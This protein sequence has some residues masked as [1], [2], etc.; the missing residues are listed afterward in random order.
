MRG[1]LLLGLT[2]LTA[3]LGI[4]YLG[5][6]NAQV[7]DP[8][9]LVA[10]VAAL[11][12]GYLFVRHAKQHVAPFIPARFLVGREF[13]LMNGI[14][15]LY[16]AAVLGFAALVPLYAEQRYGLHAL[17]AG[18]LLTARA[19]GMTVRGWVGRDDIYV[20]PAIGFPWLSGSQ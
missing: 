12:F 14:N 15:F 11:L 2:L 16:G 13:G 8:I 20:A 19:L 18:T 1:V 10:E 17:A 5:S 6:G 3:M 4:A 9:F 7:Y